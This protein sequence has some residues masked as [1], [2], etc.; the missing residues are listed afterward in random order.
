MGLLFAVEPR[1]EGLSGLRAIGR[2]FSHRG[3]WHRGVGDYSDILEGLTGID[4]GV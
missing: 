2:E 3:V 4:K 1:P